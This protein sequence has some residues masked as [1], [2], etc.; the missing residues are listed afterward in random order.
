MKCVIADKM[1]ETILPMLEEVGIEAEYTPTI[2]RQELLEI[3]GEYEGLIIRSKTNIDKEFI[4]AAT[5]LKWIAR[6]GAGIDKLDVS[7]IENA[8]ITI[9]NAPEGNRN[10]VGEHVLG[11]L[12]SMMNN[13]KKG[14]GEIRNNIW[15]REG[16][17]GIE[18]SGKTV[19]L[20][21]YGF[22]GMAVAQKMTALGCHVLAYDKYK[23]S[24]S[25]MHAVESSM[26]EIFEKADVFS[27]HVP[28]T[29][30]T[31]GLIDSKYLSS[32][33]KPIFLINT[34]RGEI[35]GLDDL[36][37]QLDNNRILGAALDVLENEKINHLTDYQ[38]I[39]FNRIIKNHKIILSPHVAGW[40]FESY[41]RINEVL[42][43]KIK[44]F[45]MTFNP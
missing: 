3:I 7:A 43:E 24:F 31:T 17:R 6:A 38:Q 30:E 33:E 12:L 13:L 21:G 42:L 20:L 5:R 41:I 40:S 14:D 4:E 11:M 28:L 39:T 16:N 22:M 37:D 9:F 27:I 44:A 35:L 36:L 8:G 19:G 34:A 32:F 23:Q 29:E 45:L 25:D 2:T 26:D 15:D 10:A 18:L 1:H